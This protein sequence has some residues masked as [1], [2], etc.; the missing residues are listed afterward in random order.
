MRKTI[1]SLGL[2]LLLFGCAELAPPPY[3][4]STGHIGAE[5]ATQPATDI[6]ELVDQAAPELPAPAGDADQER[7]TVVVNEVPVKEL[8][9]ALARD[10]KLNVDVAP[11][12][13]G[14]VTMN[15]V[16]QTLPQ[17]L[18]RIAR[19]VDLRY[20][21]DNNNLSIMPDDPFVR[22]YRV[23]YLGLA[24]RLTGDV[25]LQTSVGG[26]SG[27]GGGGGGAAA[28]GTGSTRIQ[29]EAEN[30]FWNTLLLNIN[31]MLQGGVEDEEAAAGAER[32]VAYP[33]TGLLTVRAT[34]RQHALVQELIDRA[35]ESAQRQVMIQATIAEVTLNNKYQG[36][37][38]WSILTEAG[39]AGFGIATTLLP[40]AGLLGAFSGLVFEYE[41][42]LTNSGNIIDVQVRLLEEFG[43]V[44]I[45]SSPQ[46]MTLNN[47][48]AILKVVDDIV[49]F[50]VDSTTNQNQTNSLTTFDTEAKTVSVGVTMS[51]TPQI[52]SNDT[53]ILN[54]RPSISRV[55][56]FVPDPNPDLEINSGVPELRVREM[57][58]VL[59]LQNGQIAVLGGLMENADEAINADTPGV[60]RIPGLGELFK[61]HTIESTKTELVIFLRPIV[62][63]NP[64][65]DGDLRDYKQ[66]LK[67]AR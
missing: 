15:A 52:G 49:Y 62:V 67:S 59:R 2:A 47:Q 5:P 14:V 57:E 38:D 9:F 44:N 48:T 28:A 18:D 53:V 11:S 3:E 4:T 45:L 32:V 20:E 13:D 50:E 41:D 16:D 30:Q 60:S 1:I 29:I 65:V 22:T 61:S 17:L 26:S 40:P 54:V 39:D 34:A 37:I 55:L 46:I 27:G 19:Q 23:E 24:R 33:E 56:R 8:L 10:A 35:V 12:I 21:L 64:S 36:G 63:R 51:V 31:S 42:P 43:D 66:F 6:P 58:S 25:Q 7:Y